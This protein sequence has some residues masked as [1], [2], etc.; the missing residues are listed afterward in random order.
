MQGK[1]TKIEQLLRIYTHRDETPDCFH[2]HHFSAISTRRAIKTGC[3]NFLCSGCCG[4][5]EHGKTL[6]LRPSTSFHF[7]HLSF[8]HHD[9]LPFHADVSAVQFHKFPNENWNVLVYQNDWEREREKDGYRIVQMFLSVC[10][11]SDRL[12]YKFSF[13]LCASLFPRS[14]A[15]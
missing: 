11:Q 1:L 7:S 14:L 5:A 3:W 15:L 12:A 9:D 13:I 10:R 8:H 2:F 6:F 4:A